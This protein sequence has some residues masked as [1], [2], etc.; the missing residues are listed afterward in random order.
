MPGADSSA[1]PRPLSDDLAAKIGSE[2]FQGL[3]GVS[4]ARVELEDAVEIVARRAPAAQLV[5]KKG[6]VAVSHHRFRVELDRLGIVGE[7]C[8]A[9]RSVTPEL[10][11]LRQV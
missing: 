5:I 4:V 1:Q 9:G 8:I 11:D 2:P 6:T 3:F 10:L 7:R